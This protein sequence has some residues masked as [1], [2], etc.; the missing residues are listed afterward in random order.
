MNTS[1]AIPSLIIGTGTLSR[2]EIQ[3]GE[4]ETYYPSVE[5]HISIDDHWIHVQQQAV[6]IDRKDLAVF[7]AQLQAWSQTRESAA[8]LTSMSPDAFTLE[9]HPHGR[10]KNVRVRYSLQTMDPD[11]WRPFIHTISGS[12]DLN[13]DYILQLV[14]D[15]QQIFMTLD[16]VWGGSLE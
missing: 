16:H 9:L 13:M 12:F 15:M 3:I 10:A 11:A 6:W 14:N 7:V 1:P 2:L 8:R 5:I 4:I